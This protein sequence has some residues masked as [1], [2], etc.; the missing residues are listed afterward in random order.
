MLVQC[1]GYLPQGVEVVDGHGLLVRLRTRD[2]GEMHDVPVCSVDSHRHHATTVR[3][4]QHRRNCDIAVAAQRVEPVQFGSDLVRQ[5]IVLRGALAGS[6][7][8][9]VVA[10]STA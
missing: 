10:S 9:P 3:G 8:Y 2:H 4:G 7:G 1:G 5:V 6:T